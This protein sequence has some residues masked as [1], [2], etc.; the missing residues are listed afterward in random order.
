[1]DILQRLFKSV[2]GK[3]R[4]DILLLLL[5]R[6]ELSVSN[7]AS[8]LRRKMSTISRNLS[9]LEKDNF[10]KARHTSVNVFYSIKT[11]V[12]YNYNKAI[13]QILRDRLKEIKRRGDLHIS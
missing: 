3:T 10:V 2:S 11:E 12:R 8:A 13:L 5:E 7:I 6:G 9:I 4:I 1:M